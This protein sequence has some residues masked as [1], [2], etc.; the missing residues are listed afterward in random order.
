MTIDHGAVSHSGEEL[1]SSDV[2]PCLWPLALRGLCAVGHQRNKYEF[3][4]SP[5]PL[6]LDMSPDLSLASVL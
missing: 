1:W 6:T 3:V 4:F 5:S 2:G